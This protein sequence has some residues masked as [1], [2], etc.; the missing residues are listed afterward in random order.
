M[1]SERFNVCLQLAGMLGIILSLVFV[2]LQLKQAQNIAIASQYA[3]RASDAREYWQFYAEI[4]PLARIG[5]MH[6]GH[7]MAFRAYSDDMTDEEIGLEYAQTRAFLASWDNNHYQNE[8]GFMTEEAWSMYANRIRAGC[9]EGTMVHTILMN[10][11]S[12]FRASFVR[13]C[14]QATGT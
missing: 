8:S 11:G 13:F 12:F 9:V 14:L 3:D 2:G 5:A 7:A 4:V 10:H 6:R 1:N